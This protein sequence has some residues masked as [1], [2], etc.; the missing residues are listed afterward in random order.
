MDKDSLRRIGFGDIAE[1]VENNSYFSIPDAG[2]SFWTEIEPN[3]NISITNNS[4][5][6]SV[7]INKY[8]NDTQEIDSQKTFTPTETTI[9]Y[10]SF[11]SKNNDGSF[12]FIDKD[13]LRRM[14]LGKITMTADLLGIKY[15]ETQEEHDTLANSEL[16]L[17]TSPNNGNII[18]SQ[19]KIAINTNVSG[20]I[21]TS[22]F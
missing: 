3:T 21:A 8:S 19:Q 12:G 10:T 22:I 20:Y 2:G 11:F 4:G 18:P 5:V 16:T 6:A 14:G 1:L 15:P 13:S 9:D 17:I 7:N